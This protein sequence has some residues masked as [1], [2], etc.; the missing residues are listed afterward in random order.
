LTPRGIHRDRK[1]PDKAIL[2]LS[3]RNNPESGSVRSEVWEKNGSLSGIPR[4]AKQEFVR[5]RN[6][7]RIAY[8]QPRSRFWGLV[9]TMPSK[10]CLTPRQNAMPSNHGPCP[11]SPISP[12][13]NAR[14]RI[15]SGGGGVLHR[16]PRDA[17]VGE[18]EYAGR[19]P[20]N[21]GSDQ[22]FGQS[23]LASI[24]SW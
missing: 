11:E 2:C 4:D 1:R 3:Q 6:D 18:M 10:S 12:I 5:E 17:G 7:C 22:L 24:R 16:R 21:P 23:W 13:I 15:F 19:I 14:Q 9:P 20:Q 8:Y